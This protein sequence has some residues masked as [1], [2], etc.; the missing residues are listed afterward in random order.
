MKT[1]QII[2]VLA[3]F[4]IVIL[5]SC[6]KKE[7]ATPAGNANISQTYFSTTNAS[8]TNNTSYWSYTYNIN[9]NDGS[10]VNV[11][12][13]NNGQWVAL[14]FT[15]QDQEMVFQYNSSGITIWVMSASGNTAI[16]NPGVISFKTTIT[17]HI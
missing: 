16:S 12:M 5:G 1:K 11:Y 6:K 4:A 8:W 2:S 7:T 3:L 15:I 10:S 9:I 13:N 17:S 14:P